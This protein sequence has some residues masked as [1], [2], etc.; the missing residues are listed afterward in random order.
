MQVMVKFIKFYVRNDEV[1]IVV[2]L[3]N[4]FCEPLN[5]VGGST[6]PANTKLKLCSEGFLFHYIPVCACVC[7]LMCMLPCVCVCRNVH[8][9]LVC[10][11]ASA[12]LTVLCSSNDIGSWQGFMSPRLHSVGLGS[13]PRLGCQAKWTEPPNRQTEEQKRQENGGAVR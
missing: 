10:V 7:W 3:C 6:F 11:F 5:S 2:V 1:M 4:V 9:V 12:C 8:S 13:L